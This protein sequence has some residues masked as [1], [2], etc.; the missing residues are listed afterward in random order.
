VKIQVD[1]ARREYESA[2]SRFETIRTVSIASIVIGIA[3]ALGS[4]ILLMRAIMKPLAQAQDVAAKIAGGDLGNI[5]EIKRNDEFGQLL[6]SFKSMQDSLRS[7]IG[8]IKD[9]TDTINTASQEIAQGNSDLS[10]RTEKQ[11]YSLEETSSSMEKL[12]YTVKHN[13]ENAKHA[14]QLAISASAVASKGGKVVGEVVATMDSINESSRQIVHIISVIDGIAFQ[15]NI[16]ALN[17][18][19]EAARAGEQG[20]G[21][22]V[23]A[24]EVRKL[25]Q[26]STGYAKEIR[27]LISDSVKKVESGS[28]LVAQAGQ[29]MEEIESSIQRVTGIMSEITAA[30][31]EQSQGIDQINVAITHIDGVT[32]QNAALV[33]EA[34]ATTESLKEQAK[35]L[36]V[37]VGTFKMNGR[38]RTAI[39][40]SETATVT[41][42]TPA[43]VTYVIPTG[44]AA[45]VRR[46]VKMIRPA[47]DKPAIPAVIKAKGG[48]GH[49]GAQTH[50]KSGE[51]KIL[52]TR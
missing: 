25:S 9:A 52:G 48:D 22:A 26:R 11:A 10:R 27:I 49:A 31:A 50:G 45:T 21:F 29:T 42:A 1:A 4:G 15:T 32:Q 34:A 7:I 6:T 18:A 30:S 17:A 12:T 43:A 19:V 13:A 14:N 46:P 36:A 23:V 8:Q 37:A 24:G 51:R 20:R 47:A 28:K 35:N 38:Y 41:Q 5:I 40:R 3:L 2:S 33:E 39:V 16:L 44:H